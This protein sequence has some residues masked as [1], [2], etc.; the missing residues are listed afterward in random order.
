[1]KNFAGIVGFIHNITNEEVDEVIAD[2]KKRYPNRNLE[3]I[4]ARAVNQIISDRRKVMQE[5]K[6]EVINDGSLNDGRG[7]LEVRLVQGVRVLHRISVIGDDVEKAVIPAVRELVKDVLSQET[8]L[9][10]SV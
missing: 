6:L 10:S 1:M 5:I 7:G 3:Y 9:Q 2:Y 4:R 8:S